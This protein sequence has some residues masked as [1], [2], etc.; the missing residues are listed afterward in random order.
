[1]N[2]QIRDELENLQTNSMFDVHGIEFRFTNN[3]LASLE[4]RFPGGWRTK[5]PYAAL[6][7]LDRR[8]RDLYLSEGELPIVVTE[9]KKDPIFARL[10]REE[11]VE[12][13][14]GG[15]RE[16]ELHPEPDQPGPTGRKARLLAEKAVHQVL[17]HIGHTVD[18]KIDEEIER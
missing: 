18:Q 4:K 9:I 6:T 14:E 11:E 2:F 5:M 13:V 17:L 7:L 8:N 12:D 15:G 10:R 3:L 1:M 16:V